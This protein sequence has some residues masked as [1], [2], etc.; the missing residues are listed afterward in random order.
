MAPRRPSTKPGPAASS[1]ADESGETWEVIPGISAEQAELNK[2]RHT[3][4]AQLKELQ[5]AMK[6][7][8][9]AAATGSCS[10]SCAQQPWHP[11]FLPAKDHYKQ[12]LDQARELYALTDPDAGVKAQELASTE[13]AWKDT[14]AEAVKLGM[15]VPPHLWPPG[16][17]ELMVEAGAA[18]Q[19]D[20]GKSLQVGQS[21]RT[22]PAARRLRQPRPQ[23]DSKTEWVHS[24]AMPADGLTKDKPDQSAEEKLNATPSLNKWQ[25]L[26]LRIRERKRWSEKGRLLNYAKNGCPRNLDGKAR[27]FGHHIGR[28]QWREIHYEW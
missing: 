23:D 3:V 6:D 28:W 13:A 9:G 26:V 8:T 27:G 4:A 19:Q 20:Q 1:S 25:R 5:D 15:Y 18:Y 21:V 16:W 14:L 10:S 17:Q 22:L 24:E 12:A 7:A 11:D 2:W